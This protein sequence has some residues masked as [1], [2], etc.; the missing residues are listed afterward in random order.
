MP[1]SL[2][3]ALPSIALDGRREAERILEGLANWHP[4]RL[5]ARERSGIR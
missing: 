3:D 5:Q 2:L 4:A 1:N